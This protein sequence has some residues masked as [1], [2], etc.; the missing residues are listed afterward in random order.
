M[1]VKT[2]L[3]EKNLCSLLS[4]RRDI[5]GR[6]DIM[7]LTV[8]TAEAALKAAVKEKADLLVV[9]IDMP[10]MGG[11][12]LCSA[13]RG[14]EAMKKT[15]I[16]LACTGSKADMKRCEACGANT[17]LTKPFGADS[18]YK[19]VCRAFDLP[20]R[21]GL[22]VLIKVQVEGR[23]KREPFFS[24]SRDISISGIL[25]ETDKVLARGDIIACSFY[26]PDTD[27][28]DLRGEIARVSKSDLNLFN[29]GVKFLD[30]HSESYLSIASFI[31]RTAATGPA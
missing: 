28:I 15:Y 20:E 1:I 5:L 17:F 29:Y 23:F 19:T 11:D 3:L 2:I 9:D 18:F 21:K 27:R 12:K 7:V 4:E 22:R 13:L 25:F 16:A 26:L 31:E 30:I 24:T 10:E 14:E 6:E 8:D